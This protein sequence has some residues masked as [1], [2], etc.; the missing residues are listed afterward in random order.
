MTRRT[1][2]LFVTLTLGLLVASLAVAVSPSAHVPRTGLLSVWSLASGAAKA[3]RFRQG[4][5]ELGDLEGRDI[6]LGT[7]GHHPAT[8]AGLPGQLGVD[9][10]MP[11]A[12]TRHDLEQMRAQGLSPREMSKRTDIPRRTLQRLLKAPHVPEVWPEGRPEVAPGRPLPQ[13]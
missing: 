5:R 9:T 10:P 1:V 6:L 11:S 3:E 8:C 13:R 7:A 2:R 4:V 12:L